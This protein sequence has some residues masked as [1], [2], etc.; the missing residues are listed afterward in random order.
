MRNILLLALKS[1]RNRKFTVC[2]TIISIGLSVALLLGVERIRTESRNSFTNT[3]SGTDLVVG[4]RSGPIQ[5]LLYSIFRIGYATNNISWES[6]QDIAALPSVSW[7]VPI[8]LGDSHRGYRVMG[9]TSDYFT[10]FRYGSK[11][12][13]RLDK[14][15]EFS[16]LYE[17][18][19]G[20][21]VARKLG[22][23][24]G[25]SIILSHG[26]GEVS[27][28]KHEDKPFTVVG[29]LAPTGT[30]V[31]QTIHVNLESIEAIHIDWKQGAPM[32]GVHIS[33]DQARR[34]KLTPKAITAFLV[35]LQSPIATFK[36]QRT[37]NQY[38]E[39]PLTAI[40]PGVALQQL[41]QLVG[42][43][44]KAL[45]A[46]S[47]FVVIIGLFGMLTT[48]MTSLNERRREMAILRSVGARPA[49]VFS[50]IIGESI[51]VTALAIVV[52]IV[53]LYTLLAIAQPLLVAQF[54]LYINISFF[55]NYELLLLAIVLL[56]GIVAGIIPG[57][58]IYRYSLNDGMT[59]KT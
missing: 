33:A 53:L 19:L 55:S 4:A 24:L 9:T 52:G 29:I 21:E 15:I 25:D 2:L 28:V 40:L 5:L 56:S 18:V 6:Y 36:V 35:K 39:E 7:T 46:V 47:G 32:A 34:L 27:F 58:K 30:P 37:I 11:Q 44:E 38:S 3:I 57:W 41:W 50:L 31:D 8:S 59:I 13:L 10:H 23:N 26:A 17:A 48:L 54:G 42:V 12:S 49:H 14:G 1:L 51:L 43:A 20:A 16:D 22:Y 45:M